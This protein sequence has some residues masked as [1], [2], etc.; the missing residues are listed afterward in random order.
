[1]QEEIIISCPAWDILYNKLIYPISPKYIFCV[2]T[3]FS[4]I[5]HFL[6][7]NKSDDYQGRYKC[8]ECG[9]NVI[10]KRGYE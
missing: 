9:Y 3:L 1:M 4:H 7:N 2:T 8:T 10:P 5:T 6:S